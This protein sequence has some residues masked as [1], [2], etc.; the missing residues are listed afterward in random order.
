MVNTF[1]DCIDTHAIVLGLEPL[2]EFPNID[3]SKTLVGAIELNRKEIL[4]VVEALCGNLRV[5]ERVLSSILLIFGKTF[6]QPN[7]HTCKVGLG[8]L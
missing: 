3:N 2:S 4:L 8:R 6:V 5:D 7:L 1:D